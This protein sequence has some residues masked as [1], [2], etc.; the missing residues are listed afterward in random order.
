MD[1]VLGWLSIEI[2]IEKGLDPVCIN[3]KEKSHDKEQR[4]GGHFGREFS[5]LGST[6]IVDSI[7]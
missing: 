3:W 5:E 1:L 6:E 7:R 2:I 4:L